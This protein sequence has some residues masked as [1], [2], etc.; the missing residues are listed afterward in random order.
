MQE[1]HRQASSMLPA[2]SE[3]RRCSRSP[4]CPGLYSGSEGC[5]CMH[6]CVSSPCSVV[7]R[8][9][10]LFLRCLPLQCC[11]CRRFWPSHVRSSAAELPHSVR[12]PTQWSVGMLGCQEDA[13]CVSN[14]CDLWPCRHTRAQGNFRLR[15]VITFAEY[16]IFLRLF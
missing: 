9:M 10:W 13:E 3:L 1:Q 14:V 11:C 6:V 7:P 5:I 4:G 8:R 12:R 2:P 15:H 16:N